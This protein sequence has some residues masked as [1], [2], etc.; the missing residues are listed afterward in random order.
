MLKP[1][2]G[3][4]P[5]DE[6]NGFLFVGAVHQEDSPNGD[7]LIWFLEEV[8]PLIQTTLGTDITF[9]IVGYNASGRI[10]QLAG[11]SVRI[12]G[13]MRDLTQSYGEARVFIAPTRYAAGIPHKIHEAAARGLPVVATALVATQLGWKDNAELLVGT[14]AAS[15]AQKCIALYRDKELWMKLR[16]AGLE[17]VKAECSK[18]AFDRKLKEILATDGIQGRRKNSISQN[19]EFFLRP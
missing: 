3:E 14:D 7:S 18:E 8:F 16:T 9:N 10:R 15:F 19:F 2:P 17:R 5:F 12:N 11:P 1:V 4:R 6:R 13:L